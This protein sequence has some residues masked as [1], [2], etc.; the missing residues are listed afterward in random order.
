MQNMEAHDPERFT[1]L[2]ENYFETHTVEC[3]VSPG[4]GGASSGLGSRLEPEG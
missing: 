1:S 4:L 3:Q 2:P